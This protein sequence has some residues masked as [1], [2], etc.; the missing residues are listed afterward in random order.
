MWSLLLNY[1]YH[2]HSLWCLEKA[3]LTS[4]LIS[5]YSTLYIYIACWVVVILLCNTLFIILLSINA[6]KGSLSCSEFWPLI[7]VS[8][9]CSSLYK[10]NK[11][12]HN[13]H[14]TTSES[15]T[16]SRACKNM[17]AILLITAVLA[18]GKINLMRVLCFLKLMIYSFQSA[19]RM[20]K[21][22][23]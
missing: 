15:T 5:F 21:A 20:Q 12:A 13:A 6:V 9:S 8:C 1:F 11:I 22:Y 23:Q 3:G 19:C 16:V 14:T 17:Q 18:F 10:I 4:R 7:K 2:L